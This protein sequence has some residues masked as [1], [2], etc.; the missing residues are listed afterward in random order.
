VYFRRIGGHHAENRI[1]LLVE[2]RAL[3]GSEAREEVRAC[4][5]ERWQCNRLTI[6]AAELACDTRIHAIFKNAERVRAN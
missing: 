6:P 5:S 2:P 3:L 4:A 1:G